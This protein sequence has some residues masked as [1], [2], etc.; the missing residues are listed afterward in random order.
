M[1]V[2]H[3]LSLISQDYE[4][5]CTLALSI[6]TMNYRHFTGTGTGVLLE[7]KWAFIRVSYGNFAAARSVHKRVTV[8]KHACYS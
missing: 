6:L 2:L 3:D 1:E 4:N 8:L 7:Q 5:G